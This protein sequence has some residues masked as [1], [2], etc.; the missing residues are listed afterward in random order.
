[1]MMI[2]KN[3]IE[4]FSF[5]QGVRPGLWKNL[6]FLKTEEKNQVWK[7]KYPKEILCRIIWESDDLL[8]EEKFFFRKNHNQK[9]G[10]ANK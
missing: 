8:L 9:F 4:I 2:Y 10:K 5:E 3:K 1:M 7:I 6:D